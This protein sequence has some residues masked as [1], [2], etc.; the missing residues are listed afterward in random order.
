MADVPRDV[1]RDLDRPIAHLRSTADEH[2]LA[3][4]TSVRVRLFRAAQTEVAAFVD[5]A[6][7][8]PDGPDVLDRMLDRH[9]GINPDR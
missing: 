4:A 5:M 6:H 7:R 9:P 3:L 8:R 2:G 1:V